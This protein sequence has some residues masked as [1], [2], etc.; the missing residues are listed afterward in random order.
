MTTMTAD[1][2]VLP[3]NRGH[4]TASATTNVTPVVTVASSAQPVP[5]A[6]QRYQPS[7]AY[8]QSGNLGLVMVLLIVAIIAV[9]A[10]FNWNPVATP[11]DPTFV[12][13]TIVHHTVTPVIMRQPAVVVEPQRQ[14]IVG[15]PYVDCT[16][17]SPSV[18]GSC[19]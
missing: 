11:S 7:N 2:V 1:R 10:W 9:L 12:P 8:Q 18:S 15:N 16:M 14:S 19:R 5:V 13:P 17:L 4:D 3:Y 6:D